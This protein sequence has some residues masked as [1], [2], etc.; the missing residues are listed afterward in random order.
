V[1]PIQL[2]GNE[3][4]ELLTILFLH[5]RVEY[6]LREII[7]ECPWVRVRHW[8]PLE[9][10]VGTPLQGKV[11]EANLRRNDVINWMGG[12]LLR[13]IVVQK[14]GGLYFDLD[15]LF[16]R[17]VSPLLN[18]DFI[19]REPC[20]ENKAPESAPFTNGAMM[21]ARQPNSSMTFNFCQVFI[22][23]MQEEVCVRIFVIYVC[24]SLTRDG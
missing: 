8:D 22:D 3:R 2:S 16:L 18:E 5:A 7:A 12:D 20:S 13:M 4:Y 24:K 14:Y 10:V 21:H 23:D 1:W 9:A 17:D 6:Y 19:Y 15:T 11:R